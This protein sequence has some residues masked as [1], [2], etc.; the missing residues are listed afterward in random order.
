MC[1]PKHK[2]SETIEYIL[3]ATLYWKRLFGV[4]IPNT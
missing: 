1:K 3:P 2:M 4:N